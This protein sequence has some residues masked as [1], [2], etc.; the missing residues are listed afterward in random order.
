MD[1][2]YAARDIEIG[3]DGPAVGRVFAEAFRLPLPSFRDPRRSCLLDR[4]ELA[5]TCVPSNLL[6]CQGNQLPL[7][8]RLPEPEGY[9]SVRAVILWRGDSI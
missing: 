7:P 6:R 1:A 8:G 5:G 4:N 9:G 2:R 3:V